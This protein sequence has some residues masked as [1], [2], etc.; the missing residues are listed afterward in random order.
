MLDIIY[1]ME[2]DDPD[3]FLT[4]LLL[5]GHP[6]INLK[7]VTVFPGSPQQIGFIRRAINTWFDLDIPI[8]AHNLKTP[9]PRLSVWHSLAY[10]ETNSSTDAEVTGQILLDYCDENTILVMGAPLT[11]FRTASRLADEQNRELT[12][13]KLVIQGGFA[14]EGVVPEHL[15]LEKF[16]GKTAVPSHNLI[17]DKKATKKIFDYQPQTGKYFVSK[18]VCHRVIYDRE[19]HDLVAEKRQHSQS[20]DLIYRGME[21]Y[22]TINP[23]GKML[24]DP[25]AAC[26]AI[27]ASIGE[28]CEVEIF[29]DGNA[30]GARLAENTDTY[31]IID[32][33]HQRFLRTLLTV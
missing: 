4:L 5:L 3:D 9:K 13:G 25:L 1:D 27:D 23:N 19:L 21:S 20:L 10:G 30:Y 24:H 33:D 8:G 16:K 6:Q 7:A 18:N 28:W 31:I 2:T 12:I 29:K 11:N 14:G 22:F 32:Y 15:Q 26:C 17:S